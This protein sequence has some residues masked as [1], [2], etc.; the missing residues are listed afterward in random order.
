MSIEDISIAPMVQLAS[1]GS[2]ER[3][4]NITNRKAIQNVCHSFENNKLDLL[5]NAGDTCIPLFIKSDLP[6]DYLQLSFDN[7]NFN[8][9]TENSAINFSQIK[10]ISIKINSNT[11]QN[12]I[13]RALNLNIL[14]IASGMGGV[15]YDIKE[16][17]EILNNISCRIEGDTFCSIGYLEIID[18]DNY[19]KCDECNKNFITHLL[20]EWLCI[21]PLNI[22][23]GT[24]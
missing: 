14:R 2:I 15:V 21:T 11:T 22:I 1:V 6:I 18:N 19:M 8:D 16:N 24:V 3:I 4:S 10:I 9:T 5:R 17:E 7:L 20:K 12:V 13:L 23:N